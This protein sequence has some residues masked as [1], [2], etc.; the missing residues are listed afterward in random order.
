MNVTQKISIFFLLSKLK[1]VLPR[2]FKIRLALLIFLMV[3]SAFAEIISI[4]LIIPFLSA[5]TAPSAILENT[6]IQPFLS[7]FSISS[8]NS[9]ILFLTVTF[10]VAA[11][12][13]AGLRLLTL[14]LQTRFCY[15]I[16]ANLSSQIYKNSL[17][18]SYS[19]HISRNS[20]EFIS[21]IVSK[22]SASTSFAILPTLNILS[23]SIVLFAI[24]ATLI[25]IQPIVALSAFLL[26]G[27]LYGG[28]VL[29]TKKKLN[30]DSERI[31]YEQDQ[32]IKILQ[33][34]FGSIRDIL[35]SNTQEVYLGP[36]A[37]LSMHCKKLG[38]MLKLSKEVQDI[39]LKL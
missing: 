14:W 26:F 6:F 34:G 4:G 29:L 8:N 17:Y 12:I 37:Y 30:N 33:E 21:T 1:T 2:H 10:C 15:S 38:L 25:F 5:I 39:L 27:S 20:S 13:S 3:F 18:Q 11:V 23:S 7:F 31:S 35:V 22:T 24:T 32:V 28:V 16:G 19:A 36:T 9:L